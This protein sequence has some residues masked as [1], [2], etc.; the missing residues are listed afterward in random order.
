MMFGYG[1]GLFGGFGMIFGMLFWIGLLVL[2]IWAIAS[3]FGRSGSRPSTG[4]SALRILR[5]RYARGEISLAEF[6][7]AR[8]D[9][10]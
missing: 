8:Q 3:F 2:V 6:E 4:D 1:L 7:Q 5:E 9:L 10:Q